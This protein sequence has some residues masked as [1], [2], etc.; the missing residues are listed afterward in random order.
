MTVKKKINVKKNANKSHVPDTYIYEFNYILTTL[1]NV[2]LNDS[3]IICH[4]LLSFIL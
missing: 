1:I 3:K 4:F 2:K